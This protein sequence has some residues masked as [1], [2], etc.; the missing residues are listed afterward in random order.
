[1]MEELIRHLSLDPAALRILD[2]AAQVTAITLVALGLLRLSSRRN[3]AARHAVA[4]CALFCILSS[5]AIAGGVE[6]VG[7]ASVAQ[8]ADGSLY[9][10]TLLVAG[11]WLAGVLFQ[12]LRLGAGCRRVAELRRSA[13]PIDLSDRRAMLEEVRIA[14]GQSQLPEIAASSLVRGPVVLGP[15]R[16]LVLLPESMATT[17]DDGELRDVLL[18][19]CAHLA[20]RH[21]WLCWAQRLAVVLFWPHP[22]VHRLCGELDRAREELCDN[23]VLHH[24]GAPH[25][26]RT[27]LAVACSAPP[28]ASTSPLERGAAV[29]HTAASSLESRVVALLDRRRETRTRW[30]R[31]KQVVLASVFVA[32]ACSV[33]AVRVSHAAALPSAQALK[34]PAALPAQAD[35]S[36]L[37]QRS[38]A[39][40]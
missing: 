29:R 33:S 26:A 13:R 36:S 4:L 20:Q 40:Q 35:H 10:G 16:P 19:E 14:L 18:H 3:A 21:H 32:V 30:D 24:S 34:S 39:R 8:A 6:R 31:W 22:L 38:G 1:M 2:L 28:A 5:P 11:I 9:Q 15:L 25:Y 27:L 17:L 23:F 37:K 12:L 7:P